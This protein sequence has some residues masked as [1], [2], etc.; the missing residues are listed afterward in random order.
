MILVGQF[1][2]PFV[3]RVA[4]TLHHYGTPYTRNTMSV[5]SDAAE[6]VRIN[7][8]GRVPSLILDNGEVLIDSN[9]I[10]DHLEEAAGDRANL[11]PSAGEERRRVLRL[12]AASCGVVDKAIAIVYEN[13]F[14][15]RQQLSQTW[16]RRC[17]GQVASTLRY[18]ESHMTGA[19]IAG[20]RFSQ[21]DIMTGATPGYL[22]LR[23]PALF[24]RDMYPRLAVLCDR[25][26][27]LECFAACR[28]GSNETV[29][30]P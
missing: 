2:S 14:H 10:A 22:T 19:W 12:V 17:E 4:V 27:A 3:R 5:I 26:E 6:M 29:P 16:L 8:L 21:A 20:E 9:A 1:D 25:C 23:L 30:A 7:P 11:I 18:L 13:L 15:E 24:S 28:P